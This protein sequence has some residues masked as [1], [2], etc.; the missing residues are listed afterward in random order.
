MTK[1]DTPS[2]SQS[3]AA[4]T[5]DGQGRVTSMT[6]GSGPALSYFFDP[7]GN[8]TTLPTG[9]SGGYDHASEL[10]SSV[11]SGTTTNNTYN[12]DG[13]QLTAKQGTTTIA[14]GTWNGTGQ[15]TAY[16]NAAANMTAAAYNGDGQRMSDTVSGTSNTFTWNT[17]GPLPKVIMD[18]GNAYVYATTM[19]PAEQVNLATGAIT[20][21]LTDS[22]GSVRGTVSSSGTL[23]G[24]TNYDAWG[25]PETVG[26]L[27][28]TTP[29]GYAG[30]YTDPTGLVYLLNR[31]YA[32]GEGQFL[33]VDSELSQTLQP[34]SYATGNPV[35]RIDPSGDSS[36]YGCTLR[37][38]YAHER[39][40][41]KKRGKK[42][43]GFKPEV[44]CDQF[45]TEIQIT[46]T[47]FKSA[48]DHLCVHP[49]G[50]W[51][52]T[53]HW[54]D[55]YVVK[56]IEV[57]CT[58]DKLTKWRGSADASVTFAACLPNGSNQAYLDVE[59]TP[60]TKELPCGT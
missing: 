7:S 19:A 42:A 53:K 25:N 50:P 35:S 13:E 3:P 56:N 33:S 27:T 28:A 16:D 18:S 40:S 12:A 5:Y 45:V 1:T 20:Y 47:I 49:Y 14:S 6:P 9:A 60:W 48:C 39:T 59:E 54:T 24:T 51:T 23:T 44:S 57:E 41:A 4:Y 15:L 11:L 52:R 17:E 29:F 26:G 37:A 55:N 31:Y 58:N 43:I 22:L 46:A 2:S 10:S 36:A 34:Y 38:H 21:L 30:S 8:L 32:P